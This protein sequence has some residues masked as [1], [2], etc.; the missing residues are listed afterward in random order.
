[1]LDISGKCLTVFLTFHMFFES[2]SLKEMK[3]DKTAESKRVKSIE[4]SRPAQRLS[5]DLSQDVFRCFVN[6]GSVQTF[7]DFA[8]RTFSQRTFPNFQKTCWNSKIYFDKIE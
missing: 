6:F 4:T 5:Q 1:M 8:M 7:S 2:L 3:Q